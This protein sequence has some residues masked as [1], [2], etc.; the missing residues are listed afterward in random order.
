MRASECGLGGLIGLGELREVPS[1][2]ILFKLHVLLHRRNIF[3]MASRA[4]GS[5]RYSIYFNLGAFKQFPLSTRTVTMRHKQLCAS[6]LR[7]GV[8]PC[9]SMVY[10]C[11]ACIVRKHSRLFTAAVLL[12]VLKGAAL[13]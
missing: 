12:P 9:R 11:T 3:R 13:R 7:H 10:S 2:R 8:P 5:P 1:H 4:A 6:R